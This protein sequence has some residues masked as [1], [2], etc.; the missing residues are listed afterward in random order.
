MV[1]SYDVL[2]WVGLSIS[3]TFIILVIKNL[4]NLL[5]CSSSVLP[6]GSGRSHFLPRMPLHIPKIFFKL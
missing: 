5:A 4:L 6:G 3:C 2:C 1:L